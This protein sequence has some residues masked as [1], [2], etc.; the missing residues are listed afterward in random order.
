M[1]HT[2]YNIKDVN[3]YFYGH[4]PSSFDIDKFMATKDTISK[5]AFII[6]NQETKNIFDIHNSRKSIDISKYFKRYSRTEQSKIYYYG[7]I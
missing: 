4:L 2:D 5:M 1:T 3:I 7:F 6:V